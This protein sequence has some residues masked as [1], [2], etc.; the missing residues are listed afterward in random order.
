MLLQPTRDE[1]FRRR[2]TLIFITCG[3]DNIIVVMVETA[4]TQEEE[5]LEQLR[6]NMTAMAM[7]QGNITSSWSEGAHSELA[8]ELERMDNP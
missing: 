5:R 6:R 7:R 2:R 4:V 8:L 1:F 3:R